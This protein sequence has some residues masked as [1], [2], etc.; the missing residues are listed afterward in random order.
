MENILT[1]NFADS[2]TISPAAFPTPGW[3]A[4]PQPNNLSRRLNAAIAPPHYQISDVFLPRSPKDDLTNNPACVISSV[5]EKP[6]KRDDCYMLF[7]PAQNIW[8][9]ICGSGGSNANWVRGNT[10]AVDYDRDKLYDSQKYMV[11]VP[12]F[13]K[14]PEKNPTLVSDSPFYPFPDYNMR[15]LPQYKSYPYSGSQY[16]GGHPTIR[17]PYQ[18]EDFENMNSTGFTISFIVFIVIIVLILWFIMKK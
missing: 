3:S 17:Y 14:I 15:F 10:F 8:G 7:S 6:F 9:K 4:V 18:I 12:P 1:T 16:I 11:D 2:K 5:S 13:A